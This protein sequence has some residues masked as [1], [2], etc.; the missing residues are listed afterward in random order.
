LYSLDPTQ[1]PEEHIQYLLVFCLIHYSRAIK[2]YSSYG[3]KYELMRQIP[4]L[5]DQL[6]IQ[7]AFNEIRKAPELRAW[8]GTKQVTWMLACLTRPFAKEVKLVGV[9]KP[10]NRFDEVRRETNV[11]ESINHQSNEGTGRYHTFVGAVVT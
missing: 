6:Q 4:F 5:P 3:A 11:S 2:K 10:L 1:R 7:A 9:R 8:A